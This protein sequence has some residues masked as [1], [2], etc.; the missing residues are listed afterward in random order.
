MESID[1]TK[2]FYRIREV[3]ELIDVPASTIR[4][5]ESMFPKLQPQR[6]AK[7][8]RYYTPA[9]VEMLQQIRY[10]VHDKGLK[11]DAAIRQMLVGADTV[12]TKARAIERLEGI[13]TR[14]IALRDALSRLKS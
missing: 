10:L 2:K 11:I 4:Y 14:L 3:S 13:R 1:L 8:T 12:A 5:W 6:N 9:D 7:G